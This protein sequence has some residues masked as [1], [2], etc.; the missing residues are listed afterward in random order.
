MLIRSN[1][2]NET[3]A[4]SRSK[5][6]NEPVA[7]VPTTTNSTPL[8]SSSTCKPPQNRYEALFIKLFAKTTLQLIMSFTSI[9]FSIIT[10]RDFIG[11]VLD[12]NVNI[13]CF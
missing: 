1:I 3:E 13:N 10:I 8:S 5:L 12:Y 9:F 6:F 4:T 7:P 2:L 11:K